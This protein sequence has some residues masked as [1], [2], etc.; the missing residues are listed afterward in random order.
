MFYSRNKLWLLYIHHSKLIEIFTAQGI[1]FSIMIQ[2]RDPRVGPRFFFIGRGNVRNLRA[3]RISESRIEL[4]QDQWRKFRTERCVDSWF[5]ISGYIF[6]YK[7]P[8]QNLYHHLCIQRRSSPDLY[9]HR[10]NCLDNSHFHSLNE[11]YNVFNLTLS[12]KVFDDYLDN[13]A[14]STL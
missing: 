11:I 2:S 12:S 4:H 9:Q 14:F 3:K 1:L 13:V 10:S 5:K 8:F 6:F 7:N